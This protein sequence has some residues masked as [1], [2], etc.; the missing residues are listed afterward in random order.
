MPNVAEELL[1]LMSSDSGA[2][3]R[4]VCV[5]ATGP[6]TYAR[7]PVLAAIPADDFVARVVALRFGGRKEVLLALAM[8]YEH[9]HL[10]PDLAAERP[11]IQE[12]YE[13]LM[14]HTD[15]LPPVPKAF[16]REQIDVYLK[17]I[18]ALR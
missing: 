16:L 1:Q 10:S 18:E 4:K 3:L 8:R 5:T 9:L 17:Q 14:C 2:F 11:W 13:K 15:S 7:L 12:V 6:S